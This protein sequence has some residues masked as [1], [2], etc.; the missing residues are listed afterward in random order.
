MTTQETTSAGHSFSNAFS[1]RDLIAIGFRHKRAIVITFCAML[2]G[3][4]LAAVLQPPD[5]KASTKFLIERARMDPVV[6]P[7]HDAASVRAEVTE[8]ELNSEVELLQSA[9]VLRQV[10]VTTGLH[11]RRTLLT[12]LHVPDIL[13][14]LGLKDTEEEHIAKAVTTLQK[15]L[16]IEAVRKSNLISVSYTSSDPQLAARVLQALDEAYLQ[17][18]LAVHHPE[19]EFQFFDRETENY[20][21]NLA[22]AESQL[23][24]FSEQEGGVSPQLARD[25]TLQK[26]SEF[27]GTL[28]QT[29]A[30]IAATEKRIDALEKQSGTTP[31]RLTTQASATDDAQVLQGM[32]ST[33]MTLELKRTELLTKYQPTYPLVQ[34]VDKQLTDTRASIA[35]EESKPLRAETTDRNPTYSWINEELAKAKADESGLHARAAAIQTIVAKYKANAHELDQKG[36]VQQDLLR[37]MKTEEENYLLYQ[38]KREEARM[39]D[40]LDRTRILNVAIAEQPSI[41]AVPATSRW[42]VFLIGTLL[43]LSISVGMA[44]T[45][46]Y[47]NPSFRTPSEVLSELNIPVLAAVP[48]EFVSFPGN[49]KSHHNGNGNGNGHGNGNGNGNG[50]GHGNGNG[51]RH[52]LVV[53]RDASI[54]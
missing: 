8:E 19:G 39:T 11:H 38:H 34:E 52:S 42:T 14:Y 29:Y 36:I 37:K 9:D 7:G 5:Y 26:L 54:E 21:A 23:K 13:S 43:A 25:I 22:A 16:K 40:A 53:S 24:A 4:V 49:G 6:S 15:D 44:F 30:D 2:A 10:V 27:N 1:S 45:L 28:Q 50:N 32:K 51:V 12:R 35:S 48:K 31:Q 46:E 33:L 17:K 41:P 47:A 18:N 3:A 20:K